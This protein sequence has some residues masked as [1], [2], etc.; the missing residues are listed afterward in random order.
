MSSIRFLKTFIAVAEQGSFAAAAD[1]VALTSAAV[2]QQM[3][4]LE[5][6][7]GRALFQRNHRQTSLSQAGLLLL[8]RAKRLVAD[9]EA[10]LEDPDRDLRMEGE[11]TVGGIISAMGLL[12]NCLVQ[13]KAI[14]PKVSVK[15][16]SARS[17]ELAPL[18]LA[19]ELDAA[20][21]VK[22][23]RQDFKGLTCS[24]LYDE[25]L[26]LLAS[27][28]AYARTPDVTQ[29]L[30]TQPY[31]RYDRNTATGSKA[32]RVLHRLRVKPQEILELNSILGIAALVR[33]QVGVSLVP[34]LQNVYW[35]E[36]PA[37]KV[38]PLPGPQ[39]F[40]SISIIEQGRK[41]HLTGEINR[42]LR[43]AFDSRGSA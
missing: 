19:G 39:E 37:L 35:N 13:L 42:L 15:L 8:P 1:R 27:A 30:A 26:I 10:M 3:R 24:R 36:D 34:W 12:A 33:Q 6:D 9:Y 22:S 41:R 18:L 28:E 17:D 29:L 38:L 14:H 2:G 5:D 7:M 21:V 23:P 11:I 25:P 20:V 43:V 31:I 16:T 40:R 4:A 32:A